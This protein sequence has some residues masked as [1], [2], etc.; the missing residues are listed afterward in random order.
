MIKNEQRFS[1]FLSSSL[2]ARLKDFFSGYDVTAS[3]LYLYHLIHSI[4]NVCPKSSYPFYKVSYY[5]KW[6]TT[7]WTYSIPLSICHLDLRTWLMLV[8]A[9]RAPCLDRGDE[10]R[11]CSGGATISSEPPNLNTLILFQ[12]S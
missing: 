12:A 1:F 9:R 4:I 7:S 8:R 3:L 10:N 6:V 11:A 5:I 2:T